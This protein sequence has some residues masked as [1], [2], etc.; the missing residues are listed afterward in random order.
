MGV[1]SAVIAASA[2][3]G[4]RYRCRG[5]PSWESCVTEGGLRGWWP[6]QR[7][8]LPGL[9]RSLL[10]AVAAGDGDSGDAGVRRHGCGDAGTW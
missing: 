1:T 5:R 9:P 8:P 3:A 6:L 7:R 4:S 10:G 2:V